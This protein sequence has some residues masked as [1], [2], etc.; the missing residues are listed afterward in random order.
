MFSLSKQGTFHKTYQSVLYFYKLKMVQN[1]DLKIMG[2]KRNK[3][4]LLLK[5]KP[6]VRLEVLEVHTS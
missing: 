6:S 3:N 1:T 2:F 5:K 4:Y